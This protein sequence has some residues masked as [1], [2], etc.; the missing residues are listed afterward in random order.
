MKRKTRA[1]VNSQVDARNLL[2]HLIGISKDHTVE[3]SVLIHS[4]EIAECC[5]LLLE[6]RILNSSELGLD[7]LVVGSPVV[8]NCKNLECFIF[9]A[10][11][12]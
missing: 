10:L 1:K 8:Q 7:D 6:H 9:L 2:H 4:E 12:N 3:V 5:L 11:Q